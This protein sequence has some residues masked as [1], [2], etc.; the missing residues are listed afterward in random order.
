M[1]NINSVKVLSIDEERLKFR[2]IVS[3]DCPAPLAPHDRGRFQFVLPPP[4]SFANSNEYSSCTIQCDGFNA[5]GNSAVGDPTWSV[6]APGA[7]A[8]LAKIA[9]IELRMN[10]GSSQSIVNQSLLTGFRGVGDNRMGGYRQ[11]V[12]LALK[13]VGDSTG[14]VVPG[15]RSSAWEGVGLGE[16]M[17]CGNPF[18]SQITLSINDIMTDS[19]CYIVSAA[20]AAGS[21]D[22]GQYSAQFTIV[23]VPNN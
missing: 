7:A 18:G 12:N 20:A 17:L 10:V 5:L 22:L 11:M 8:Q 13:Y 6:Q 16:P 14:V 2:V 19:P 23:M 1:E 9:A 3:F 15:A 4:T 21:A